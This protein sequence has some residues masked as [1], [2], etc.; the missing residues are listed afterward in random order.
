[1]RNAVLI[2]SLLG[3][4]QLMAEVR[5]WTSADGR[6]I[7]AEFV[8]QQKG[9][10]TLKMKDGREVPVELAK[11]SAADQ[12]YVKKQGPG[13]PPTGKRGPGFSDVIL[14]K[15]LWVM[16]PQPE[17]FGI[18]AIALT[19]QLET[20]HFLITAGPKVKPAIIE[21]YAE[22][23]ERLYA[24][25]TRDL[26][27]LDEKFKDRKITIWLGADQAEMALIGKCL[28]QVGA[29]APSWEDFGITWARFPLETATQKKIIPLARGFNVGKDAADQRNVQWT[30]RIHFIA[31]DI[32]SCYGHLFTDK[33]RGF[34]F[35]DLCYSYY[36]EFDITGKIETKVSFSASP[37]IVEGFKNPKG[38]ASATR[39]ILD[40]TPIK[41]SLQR[42][43]TLQTSQAEP[44]DLGAGFGLMQYIFRDPARLAALNKI[45]ENT[46]KTQKPPTTD[47][48]A[49]AMGAANATAFEEQWI[50][51]LESDAFK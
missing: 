19:Q 29:Q 38:W 49:I 27:G 4:S 12:D 24:H 51:F 7:D 50:A 34:D 39:R 30:E 48:F 35:F 15:K 37:E 22:A 11:L 31:S 33:G 14:D 2:L 42:V 26:R 40:N 3:L 46:R 21:T 41:P 16:R 45:L 17:T 18:T 47:E 9:A 20:P 10:V 8:R 1:M 28:E 43:F 32:I 6:I 13:S 5:K 44:I 23:G 25:M 36:I